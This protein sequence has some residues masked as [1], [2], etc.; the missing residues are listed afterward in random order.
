MIFNIAFKKKALDDIKKI[1][2]SGRKI[3]LN[4]LNLIFEELK[5]HPKTGIGNPEPL[6]HHLSGFWSLRINQKDRLIYEIIEDP[7]N[8]VGAG[9]L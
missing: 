6:K 2:S 9:A 8:L 4:K 1:K 7:N 5:I 3:D